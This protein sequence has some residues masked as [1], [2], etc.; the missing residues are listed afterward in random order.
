M[1][2]VPPI[3]MKRIFAYLIIIVIFSNCSDKLTQDKYAQL[4]KAYSEQN[5]FKLDNLMS[6][7][8]LNKREPTL[9]LCKAKLDYVFNR[10]ESSNILINKIL[11]KYSA[12]FNDTIIADLYFMKSN[13]EDRL[14]DYENACLNAQLLLEKYSHVYDSS[15]IREMED[16]IL[17]RKTLSGIPKMVIKQDADTRIPI[18]RDIAGLL[19]VPVIINNDSTDFIFDTGANKSVIVKSLANKYGARI[20]LPKINIYGFTGYRFESE[21]CLID[22]KI[23]DITIKN[24]VFI[25]LPDSLLSFGNGA[26]VIKGIIGFPVISALKELIFEDEKFLSIPKEPA[27]YNLRN[28][29]LR[30]ANPVI[31]VKYRNDTLPFHF[32]TGA[33]RTVLFA[34]F[35]NKYKDEITENYK[36]L[37]VKMAGA[38]GDIETEAYLIDSVMLSAGEAQLQLDSLEVLTELL[39]ANQRHVYGNF[40]QDFIKNFSKMEI[41][42]KSMHIKF[43]N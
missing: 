33:D 1:G 19:N 31:L 3:N 17:I 16:D 32:D 43:S 10:P 34:T 40:G 22:I 13:N 5:Y 20:F 21:L 26:Y 25:V 18:K 8:K 2:A 41:N 24:S 39:N 12:Y 29:A 23:G 9:L 37:T 7:T 38:G 11:D 36:K 4:I 42:F 6:E 30:E 27:Q 35:L 15:F 28:F 14:Q